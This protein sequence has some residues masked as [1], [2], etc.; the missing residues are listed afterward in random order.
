M[1]RQLVDHARPPAKFSAFDPRVNIS[2]DIH[3]RS[4]SYYAE[5]CCVY[6]RAR[7]MR[8]LMSDLPSL[9]PDIVCLVQV[10]RGSFLW[11]M[12]IAMAAL[13]LLRNAAK[14]SDILRHLAGAQTSFLTGACAL[15]T[16]CA[17][18]RECC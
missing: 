18:S 12:L 10:M 8:S 17:H 13:S 2:R 6:S 15:S 3:A 4:M 1:L 16:R 11:R 5:A 9:H 14:R 7:F